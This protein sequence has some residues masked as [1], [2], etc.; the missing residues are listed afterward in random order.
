MR[1]YHFT[2]QPYPNAWRDDA[3]S[4][5]ISLP[6]A[7]CDPKIAA[8]LYN[9]YL[10]EWM[11]ADELGF[12]IMLNEHHSTSTCMTSA[13]SV[14][15]GALARQTKRARLLVLGYPIANRLDPI[16]AAEELAMVDV[17]SR[18]RLDMGLVKGVPYE[19]P[20]AV[21]SAVRMMDRFWEAHDLIIKA[22]T[23]HE[24][25]FNWDGDNFQ[26]RHVNLWPRPYQSPHPPVWITALGK[27]TVRSVAE[28]NYV[29]ATIDRKSVV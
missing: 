24:Q 8:D 3:P 22:M 17:I 2:E 16:R 23:T 9:R 10:D 28:R 4:L 27:A 26:Y 29:V 5:R 25:S 6:N 14:V 13:A 12:E 7:E 21:K 20:V 18:G 11:L 19:L 15:L 1:V